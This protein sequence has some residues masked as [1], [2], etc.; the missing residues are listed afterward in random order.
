MAMRKVFGAE[1][2]RSRLIARAGGEVLD[3]IGQKSHTNSGQY[4]TSNPFILCQSGHMRSASPQQSGLTLI[5]V[6]IALLI[7]SFGTAS[8]M[9]ASAQS[10]RLA[11]DSLYYSA[12]LVAGSDLIELQR[13]LL[14]RHPELAGAAGFPK[15]PPALSGR[16]CTLQPCEA[17]QLQA[18]V[19]GS[20]KCSL[21]YAETCPDV[22]GL[23]RLPHFDAELLVE[24]NSNQMRLRLEWSVKRQSRQL[25]LRGRVP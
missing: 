3:E 4:R 13:A 1:R 20:W 18:F 5:E 23:R 24:A 16:D 6:L 25:T 9:M 14:R 11:K 10:G 2:L 19:E 22:E 7:L 21:G 12:A 15:G 17:T 8:L